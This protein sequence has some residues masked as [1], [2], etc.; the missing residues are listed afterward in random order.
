MF[1]RTCDEK[2]PM[3]FRLGYYCRYLV[4][5]S[6]IALLAAA[7]AKPERTPLLDP[8]VHPVS[9]D[10]TLQPALPLTFGPT[11][12]VAGSETIVVDVGRATSRIILNSALTKISAASIDG[13]SATVVAYPKAQQIALSAGRTVDRG[14]HSI[15]L[16]FASYQFRDAHGWWLDT[17][18]V[19][20]APA[21]VSNFELATARTLFPCFDEP[22]M[23]ASFTIHTVAPAG[24]KAISNMPVVSR[25]PLSSGLLRTT[26]A[27]TPPMPTYLLTIDIGNFISE[28]ARVGKT[29]VTVYVRPGQEHL[30]KSVLADATA[31]LAFYERDLGVPYPLPKLDYVIGSGILND[32]SDGYGAITTY[33]EFDVSGQQQQG[34]IRGRREAFDYVA[35][36]IAKQWFG[37]AVAIGGW[38]D[39]FVQQ[40]LGAYEEHRAER[41]L[42]PEFQKT[43]GDA[44]D[45]SWTNL[46][47]SKAGTTIVRSVNDDRDFAVWDVLNDRMFSLGPAVISM[48]ASYAGESAMHDA[49]HRFLSTYWGRGATNADFWSSFDDA[50]ALRYGK[51]WLY[52]PGTPAFFATA[53]CSNGME[54]LRASQQPTHAAFSLARRGELW[55]I[56]FQVSNGGQNRTL[57]LDRTQQ[58]FT[59][60]SCASKLSLNPGLRPPYLTRAR[61][62]A[63]ANSLTGRQRVYDDTLHLYFT[64]LAN[65]QELNKA[66]A[67]FSPIAGDDYDV[68]L[69]ENAL[70][71]ALKDLHGTSAGDRL[72]DDVRAWGHPLLEKLGMK[73]VASTSSAQFS[74]MALLSWSNDSL[75]AKGAAAEFARVATTPGYSPAIWGLAQ[76]AA[77]YRDGALS[78]SMLPVPQPQAYGQL[79]F[80]EMYLISLSDAPSIR[81]VLDS[82]KDRSNFALYI[83]SLGARNPVVVSRYLDMYAHDLMRTAPP[84]QQGW[85]LTS[86]VVNGCWLART[87]QQWQHFFQRYIPQDASIIH[88]ATQN[89]EAK[90]RERLSLQRELTSGSR[91]K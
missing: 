29:P 41:A 88:N 66:L 64:R 19:E 62:F 84:T 35:G 63:T 6:T 12:P 58:T 53:S 82:A 90:W 2:R 43:L 89:I 31:A 91:P 52:Q 75:G 65:I 14:R 87:P 78:D 34:G 71:T 81:R 24:L 3:A 54:R 28:R 23:R 17:N 56:P 37:G 57:L 79:S 8:G 72:A 49:I 5:A 69:G 36:P 39:V 38:S 11:K 16:T 1:L 77:Q 46:Y 40:S 27:P 4:C 45:F 76:L 42:H 74:L 47:D 33:T 48:W 7:P 83:T 85:T 70:S 50:A 32:V 60:G 9:Y 73:P 51:A 80:R 15:S 30:A 59:L 55:P 21:L 86:T 44:I 22:R 68:K 13:H 67:D 20:N 25:V 26:F 18:N 10:L 61:G